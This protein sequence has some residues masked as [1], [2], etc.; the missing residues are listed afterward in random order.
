MLEASVA[1]SE[2]E[3]RPFQAEQEFRIKDLLEVAEL[4]YKF[5]AMTVLLSLIYF[6]ASRTNMFEIWLLA[7]GLAIAALI[8]SATAPYRV[9]VLLTKSPS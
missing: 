4:I 2:Q 7:S 3:R 1:E 8:Y 6:A 9:Y 5:C